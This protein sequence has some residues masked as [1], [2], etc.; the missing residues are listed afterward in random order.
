[1][2]LGARVHGRRGQLGRRGAGGA[3]ERP[4]R[5]RAA[6]PRDAGPQ[7]LR[8]ALRA[9][10]R[11]RSAAG[12]RAD[13]HAQRRH[14]GRG[15]EA[16][17]RRLRD[18]ALRDR[19]AAHQGAPAA[20]AARA[21]STRSR[22]CA[23]ASKRASASGALLGRS[24]A[25]REVFRTAAPRRG[26]ARDR[27]D[28]RRERHRQ[29][30]GGAR[31][32]RAR[33]RAPQ[34]PFVALNCAA[35][36]ASLIESELFGH[37]RGAFTDARE[38]RIGRFEAASGG[39]L[40]LDEIGEL[41]PARAGEAPARARG[42]PRRARRRRRADRRSTCAWSRRRTATSS[43]TSRRGASAPTSSTAST[44]CRSSCR[45][46]ASGARTCGCSPSTS[47]RRRARRR[48]AD[49][50]AS[51]PTRSPRSSASRGPATCASCATPIE[52]AVALCEGD[53]IEL[54]DLPPAIVRDRA[55]RGAA[56]SGARRAPARFEDAVAD[57]ERALLLEALE[58]TGWNQ[59]RAAERLGTTRRA[60]K[61]RID[62]LGAEAA[63]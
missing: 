49:R 30:A 41:E 52:R 31:D 44:W 46:C 61:L 20:R 25:M 11:A 19:G 50:G 45:R 54:G 58:E 5:P 48:G 27:A 6:R 9:R 39:T 15:D 23:R 56:R 35:M 43:A 59:T 2:L 13:G 57:F 12:D 63:G 29:G 37:E 22:R 36:P 62:R 60:L 14:G 28:P 4:A 10:A 38:R 55:D 53:A 42:A 16:R 24:A 17:R 32:P 47:S 51:R 34:A 1:M 7:R 26:L 21:A 3:R 40:F 18:Q 33:R 8:P